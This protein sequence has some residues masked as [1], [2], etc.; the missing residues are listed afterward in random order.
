MKSD[1]H[2]GQLVTWKDDRGFGFIQPS[3]GGK[4]VFLHISQVKTVTRRPQVGDTIFYQLA[5]DQ[6]GKIYASNA[7]IVG[8]TAQ[9]LA[10]SASDRRNE[11]LHLQLGLRLRC[12]LRCL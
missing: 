5:T 9:A 6:A 2:K 8:A 11:P 10:T 12:C 3:E 1:L 7:R 4:E